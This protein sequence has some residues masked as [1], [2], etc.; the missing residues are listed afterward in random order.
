MY[1][2]KSGTQKKSKPARWKRMLRK[3]VE[4]TIREKARVRKMR[5]KIHRKA[6]KARKKKVEKN[7]DRILVGICFLVCLAATLAEA[8]ENR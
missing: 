1:I 7:L 8:R 6:V 2:G 3:E 5:E 4:R